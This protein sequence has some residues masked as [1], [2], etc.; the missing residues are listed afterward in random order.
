VRCVYES[1]EVAKKKLVLYHSSH[2]LDENGA[3]YDTRKKFPAVVFTDWFVDMA[4]LKK[5][6][7]KNDDKD[8]E[9]GPFSRLLGM[10]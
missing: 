3:L 2:P 7:Y 10:W 4:S 8:S 5:S 6:S 1:T 9:I